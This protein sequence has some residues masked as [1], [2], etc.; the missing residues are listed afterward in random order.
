M[1]V[2]EY[3]HRVHVDATEVRGNERRMSDFLNGIVEGCK[4]LFGS[5]K[6]NLCLLKEK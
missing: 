3:V 1:R 5:W 4:H 6:M 2:P